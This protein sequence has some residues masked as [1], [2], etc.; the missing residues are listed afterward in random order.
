M[1]KWSVR[2]VKK[3]IQKLP[4]KWLYV[5]SVAKVNMI[6]FNP[7]EKVGC[8]QSAPLE[9]TKIFHIDNLKLLY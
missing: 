9:D 7:V 2:Y 3:S 6:A 1:G 8:I 4:M 5:I